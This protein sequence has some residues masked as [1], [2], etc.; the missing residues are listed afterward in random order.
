MT[1]LYLKSLSEFIE[2]SKILFKNI[3]YLW[4]IHPIIRD[5]Y[6]DF[7][8]SIDIDIMFSHVKII[9]LSYEAESF[10]PL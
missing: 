6:K 3:K 9:E 8:M 5:P 7:Y 4:C 10:N 2:K 1:V